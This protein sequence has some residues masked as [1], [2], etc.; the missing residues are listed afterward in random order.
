VGTPPVCHP[1]RARESFG[2]KKRAQNIEREIITLWELFLSKPKEGLKTQFWV[3]QIGQ[4]V[5]GPKLKPH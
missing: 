5:V 4:I 1:Q 3:Y 2:P